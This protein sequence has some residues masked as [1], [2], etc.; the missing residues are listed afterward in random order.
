MR[1]R[2]GES[3]PG[4][5]AKSAADEDGQELAT[6]VVNV[7]ACILLGYFVT[8]L[9]E[10]LPLSSYRRPL[11]GTGLCGGLSTFST[12]QVETVRML[13]R[14]HY[15]LAIGYTVASIAAGLLAVYVATAMVRRVGVRR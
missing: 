5:G 4:Q 3:G 12:M 10:R 8:R 2:L 11:W 7:L 15:G 6:V 1:D 9:Q 13:E 14:H